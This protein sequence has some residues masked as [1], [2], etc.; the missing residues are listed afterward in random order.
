M[1]FFGKAMALLAL[2]LVMAPGVYAAERMSVKADIANIR[3]GPG[4]QYELLWQIEKYYPI[5]VLEKKG[6]WFRFKDFAGDQGWIDGALLDKTPCVIVRVPHCNLRTGPGT[7]YD[8][9]FSA[10]RG[11]PFK[12]LQTKGQWTQVQHENGDKG[13]IFNSLLW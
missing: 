11:A 9:A 2:L 5:L 1:K 10:N 6:E 4:R 12:K 3:S 7:Q 13:W 8:V